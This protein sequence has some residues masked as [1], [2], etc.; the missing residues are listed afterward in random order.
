MPGAPAPPNPAASWALVVLRVFL[1]WTMLSTGMNWIKN[2]AGASLVE[3]M[4]PRMVD[5]PDWYT[6]VARHTL[7]EYPAFCS[8]AIQWLMLILGVLLFVGMLV[9]PVGLFA[10]LLLVVFYFGWPLLLQRYVLL[11]VVCAI[12]LSIGRA[13]QR[14]GLDGFID[15][16]W[17]RW[18]T[19]T[20]G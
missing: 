15:A 7:F 9:R 14:L 20:G 5:A 10:A 8:A 11:M 3:N 4:R 2:G 18:L 1:G 12:A 17:P 16:T 6:S 13:G 19:W